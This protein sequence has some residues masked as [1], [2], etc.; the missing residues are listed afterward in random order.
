MTLRS[1]TIFI[2]RM[3]FHAFHGVMPQERNVGGDFEVSIRVQYNISK[4]VQTDHV[5]DTLSYAELYDVV[6]EQMAQSSKLLEHVGGRIAE[7]VKSRFP[8]ATSVWMSITK[9]NPPMGADCAGAG[10]E[11][12]FEF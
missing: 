6:K 1:S 2:D 3:H 11:A 5:D 8:E 12:S 10:V 7:A 4:A 9:L